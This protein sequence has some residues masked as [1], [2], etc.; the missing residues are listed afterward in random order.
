M[1]SHLKPDFKEKELKEAIKSLEAMNFDLENIVTD[2]AEANNI[3]LGGFSGPEAIE[4]FLILQILV[5]TDDPE[6][7]KIL[8]NSKFGKEI[9]AVVDEFIAEDTSEPEL[10]EHFQEVA[11][12]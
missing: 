8:S 9:L 5:S 3:A 7:R 1:Y 10:V 4:E 11:T 2:L 6:A 12:C